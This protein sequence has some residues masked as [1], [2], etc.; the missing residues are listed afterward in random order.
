[1]PGLRTIDLVLLVDLNALLTTRS[2]TVAARQLTLSQSAMSGPLA[3][4]R[5]LVD[6]PLLVRNGRRLTPTARAEAL[7]EP[8]RE[9]V[10]R[11]PDDSDV[12]LLHPTVPEGLTAKA[13]VGARACPAAAIKLNR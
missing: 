6:D 10:Y 3:R 12:E 13:A 11:L 4:L 7:A 8:I 1:M 2:V 9:T 5:K